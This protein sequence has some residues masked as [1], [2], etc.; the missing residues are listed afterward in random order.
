MLKNQIEILE[1]S[2]YYFSKSLFNGSLNDENTIITIQSKG[3]TNSYGWCTVD[4]AWYKGKDFTE[5][6][7]C[8]QYYEINISAEHLSR[9]FYNITETLLHEMV[10]LDNILHRIVDCN[11]KQNHNENFKIG[12]ERIGL[13]VEKVKQYG[14]ANT[15][16]GDKLKESV[17][18][19]ILDKNID[20]KIFDIA[21]KDKIIKKVIRNNTKVKM[22]CLGCRNVITCDDE[23]NVTCKD[24]GIEFTKK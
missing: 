13:I 21:R 3:K 16:L 20:V 10:H 1:Q 4:S 8:L 2:F 17:D 12:A 7:D 5:E 23:L 9:N 6:E 22:I 14:Y 18:K 19:F 11:R 15:T 24:C